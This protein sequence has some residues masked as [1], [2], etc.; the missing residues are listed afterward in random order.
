MCKKKGHIAKAFRSSNIRQQPAPANRTNARNVSGNTH[1]IA[2][3]DHDTVSDTSESYEL[4]EL[5]ETRSKPL[6][7]TVKLDKAETEMEVDTGA[8]LSLISQ[9]TF[10]PCGPMSHAPS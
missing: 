5:Q 4:F 9:K 2:N 6:V 8:S 1:Q 7:V 3:A 10:I